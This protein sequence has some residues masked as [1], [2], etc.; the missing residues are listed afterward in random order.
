M[1]ELFI[2]FIILVSMIFC[3]IIDDYYIQSASLCNLKQKKWWKENAPERFYEKD[4]K[5]ALICHGFSWAFSINIP[6]Y[7]YSILSGNYLPILF[8]VLSLLI[9][10]F[11]HAFVDNLK[12]NKNEIN[13][14]ADQLI[15]SMQILITWFIWYALMRY[16]YGLC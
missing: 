7:L 14:T 10:C 5:V 9:N 11:I 15:H 4:Y 12:A 16:V 3:H 2:L 8:Y 6:I 13:L 1:Q